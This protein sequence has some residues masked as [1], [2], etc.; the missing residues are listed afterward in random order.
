V[1]GTNQERRVAVAARSWPTGVDTRRR[2]GVRREALLVAALLVSLEIVFIPYYA[3]WAIPPL[4]FLSSYT[5]DAYQWW[6]FGGIL[7]PPQWLPW[8]WN[9]YPAAM[10]IQ[11][12][13]W[14][15]P[16][17]L[18]A[19][20]TAYTPH[21]AAI[22]QAA[23][24][25]WG[26]LGANVLAR[27]TGLGRGAGALVLTA[28]F[29]APGFFSGAAHADLVRGWAWLPWLMLICSPRWP[30]QLRGAV[31]LA[32]VVVWQAL[33]GMYPGQI[34]AFAYA[35]LVWVLIWLGTMRADRRTFAIRLAASGLL[36]IALAAPKYLPLVWLQS[37][38]FTSPDHMV[39]DLTTL[40]TV[41]LPHESLSIATDPS[42]RVYWIPAVLLI[43]LVAA[44]R[45]ARCF[46]P[47]IGMLMTAAALGLPLLATYD[48]PLPGLELSR[49]QMNDF[50]AVLILSVILVAA[51][52]A[53]LAMTGPRPP[54]RRLAITGAILVGGVTALVFVAK[55]TYAAIGLGFVILSAVA[56]CA[57]P[58]LRARRRLRTSSR[59]L[60][61]AVI[62]S[63]GG[64]TF[65]LL[66]T[67][68]WGQGR[69]GT[70][71]FHYGHTASEL[72]AATNAGD[73][74]SNRRPARWLPPAK[75]KPG[76]LEPLLD[77][78]GNAAVYAHEFAVY[79]YSNLRNSDTVAAMTAAYHDPAQQQ[80]FLSFYGAPGALAPIAG[81]EVLI[82]DGQ[83]LTRGSCAGTSFSSER[84]APGSMA[85]SIQSDAGGPVAVNESY[86]PGWQATLCSDAPNPD[87]RAESVRQG[88]MGSIAVN[89][90]A[91][92][93]TLTLTY[94]TPGLALGVLAFWVAVACL[95]AGL[96]LSSSPRKWSQMR[97]RSR[98]WALGSAH[99]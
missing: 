72:L 85:F 23:H 46:W 31:P 41:V 9:G 22:V 28:Y 17:G 27:R 44:D 32:A 40:A 33:V 99:D 36:G 90:P 95:V 93:S 38:S 60:V 10:S 11:S 45:R 56:A 21:V 50:R 84:Y 81:D 65:A 87:C 89:V 96:L 51:T 52:G 88:P 82:A 26:A 75:P 80:S 16:V 15:L 61:L 58:S 86:Y 7:N 70:E 6:W 2:N 12:G 62:V 73:E 83:C 24:V 68:D 71:R 66:S 92:P 57:L 5:T 59:W 91:G 79:G 69:V 18:A 76:L 42:M 43:F 48:L 78:A 13:S 8:Q 30:W 64:C 47:A 97:G 55:P 94:V 20:I 54:V 37:R 35:L 14:Y 29:F 67:S 4:D 49:F 19:T 98:R 74:A 3:G 77:T 25:G 53:Q 34:V 1:S 39:V 63:A